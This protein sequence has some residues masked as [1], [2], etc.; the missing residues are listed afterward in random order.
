MK[1]AIT[2]G[3]GFVGTYFLEFSEINAEIHLIGRQDRL[4][5]EVCGKQYPYHQTDYSV[6]SLK[7]ILPGYD[8][9][10][11]LAAIKVIKSKQPCIEQ[12]SENQ[13]ISNNLFQTCFEN[14]I[15][16][17]VNLSSRCVYSCNS[18]SAFLESQQEMPLN[19][20]GVSKLAVEKTAELYNRKGVR[21]KSLRPGIII[22]FGSGGNVMF[23]TFIQKALMGKTLQIYGSGTDIR[24]Y[25]YIRDVVR[26]ID[27]ALQRPDLY[28][29]FNI[30]MNRHYS[31]LELASTINHILSNDENLKLLADKKDTGERFCLDILS[32]QKYLDF[33]PLWDLEKTVFDLCNYMAQSEHE[34][35][36]CI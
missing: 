34:M 1:I 20:Y 17:I 13:S 18:E 5:F 15:Q 35:S 27:K 36:G 9:V 29:V 8:A 21:I 10:V 16:N 22:G 24:H 6:E 14:G 3:T 7:K 23:N 12:Y 2:G 11:H 25:V 26:A 19:Y 33:V 28:G 31:N 32:A 30:A 4:A